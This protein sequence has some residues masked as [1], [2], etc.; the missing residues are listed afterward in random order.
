MNFIKIFINSE[1]YNNTT[2]NRD[3][4]GISGYL[5]TL[6]ISNT[7]ADPIIFS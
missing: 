3:G 1:F 7:S 6:N 4:G 5:S 2:I